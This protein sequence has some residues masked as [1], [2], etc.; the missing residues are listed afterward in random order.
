MPPLVS[1]IVPCYNYGHFLAECLNSVLQQTYG[2]WECVV[3]DNGSTDNT[4]EVCKTFTTKDVRFKYQY[5]EQKGVSFARNTGIKH[6]SGKYILPLDADDK[7]EAAFLE[8]TVNAMESHPEICLVYSKAR[9]FG[10]ASREWN[11]P[12]YHFKDLLVENS[13]F[14]TALYRRSDYDKTQGY[15][16]QMKEGFEDWDF[17]ISLLKDGG[18]VFKVPEV[19]F[20]YRIRAQSRN[21][22]LDEAKQLQLRKQIYRQHKE[23]YE[24][25]FSMPELLFENYRLKGQIRSMVRSKEMKLGHF[26]LSPLHRLFKWWSKNT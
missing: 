11:L 24:K 8:K 15:N 19:L 25:A 26:L 10:A 20:N 17:W 23:A 21:H 12:E 14:C 1:I 16:E 7:I 13:I 5:T 6:S 2:N 9:L 18:K 22:S 4:S 3:V